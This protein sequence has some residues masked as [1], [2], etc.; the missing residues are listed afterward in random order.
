MNHTSKVF[1]GVLYAQCWEDPQIDRA[2]FRITPNDTVFTI[3]SGGCN[4]LTFLLDDPQRVI[5]L[6]LNPHQN[7][8]LEL[9]MAALRR[10]SYDDL[11]SFLGIDPCNARSEMY[12]ALRSE[13]SE[14]ARAFWDGR[15]HD[16]DSGI[17]HCGR[18]ERY[19]R[20]LGSLTRVLVG[21]TTVERMFMLEDPEERRALYDGSWST[22]RWKVFTRMFLSRRCMS[23]LFDAAFFAQLDRDFSFGRHFEEIIR[24]A[25]TT[26]PVRESP[27]LAYA[28]LGHFL[29]REHL[30]PYLKRENVSTIRGRLDRITLSVGDCGS[31][32][33]TLPPGSISRF[34]F[35][36]IFE[37]MPVGACEGLLRETLRVATDRA[38]LT[39]RNLLVPRRHPASLDPQIFGRNAEAEALHARD[40]SFIY[41]A[42]V[43]EEVRTRTARC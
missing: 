19:M 22:R 8:L 27:F 38:V 43:V 30:P 42:Y 10:L 4:A 18:F 26:L 11:L 15:Q 16:I 33:R 12:A 35:T 9:K 5:A 13:L 36:N 1:D 23:L 39:Y 21:R 37:W 29:D 20:L 32:F 41:G 3:T 25:L 6:D 17:I 2:A 7:H 24:R 31:Y 40:L 34:N 28:L 14:E